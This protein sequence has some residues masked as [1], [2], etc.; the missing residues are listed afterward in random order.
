[1]MYQHIKLTLIGGALA[2]VS[3][4]LLKIALTMEAGEARW[5]LLGASALCVVGGIGIFVYGIVRFRN[6]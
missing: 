4:P 2:C 3:F 1:M 5:R 6:E